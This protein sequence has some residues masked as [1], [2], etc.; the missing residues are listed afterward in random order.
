MTAWR[1]NSLAADRRLAEEAVRPPW[2]S[3]SGWPARTDS[4]H[5]AGA[6]VEPFSLQLGEHG[7]VTTLVVANPSSGRRE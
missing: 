5:V 4:R 6:H 1:K 7:P 3:S 2:P